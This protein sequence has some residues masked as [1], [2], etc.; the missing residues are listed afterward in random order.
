MPEET[1][2]EK[3]MQSLA[4]V[5]LQDDARKV[6]AQLSGGM[7]KRAALARALVTEPEI[8]FFDEP[9]TGL[10]PIIGH[11]ILDLIHGC[12]RD[13]R[14][15]G[16]IV[17]HQLEPV[18][19][20][21]SR[22]AMLHKGTIRFTGTPEEIWTS[23]DPLVREFVSGNIHGLRKKQNRKGGHEQEDC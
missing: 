20:I 21:V 1:V 8:M 23:P 3:V 18:F 7:T 22:V 10:D 9:T 15:T 2:R 13:C 11:A 6:P 16:V 19:D 17:T 4:Q 5:G 14:F 12:Q